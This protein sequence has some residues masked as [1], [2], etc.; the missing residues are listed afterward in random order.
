M[1]FQ[2]EKGQREEFFD[3]IYWWWSIS[4]P[5]Q[6]KWLVRDVIARKDLFTGYCM[7]NYIRDLPHELRKQ[8]EPLGL[9]YALIK[10]EGPCE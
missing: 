3:G 7:T 4:T 9:A 6:K 1:I 10:D 2:K 8:L 5:K